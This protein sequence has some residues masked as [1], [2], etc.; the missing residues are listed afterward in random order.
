MA[1]LSILAQMV[2]KAENKKHDPN[3]P[4]KKGAQPSL[5]SVLLQTR[6]SDAGLK[7]EME[8]LSNPVFQSF[9]EGLVPQNR[10]AQYRRT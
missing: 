5:G 4:Q 3:R 2:R 8:Y 9:L 6:D 10:F 1:Q 7:K